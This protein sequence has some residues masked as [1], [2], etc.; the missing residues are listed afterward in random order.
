MTFEDRVN[1]D[2]SRGSR[3]YQEDNFAVVN[4]SERQ[5]GGVEHTLLVLADGMG[6]HAGGREAS[7]LAVAAFVDR[8]RRQSG[9]VP[10]RLRHSLH[11]ANDKLAEAIEADPALQDMGCTLVGV[12]I[13]QAGVQWVSVGDSPLWLVSGSNFRQLNTDHSMTPVLQD[14]VESGRMTAEEAA[15]DRRRNALRSAV[16]GDEIPMV[17]LSSQPIQLS[18]GDRIILASDGLQTLSEA[19]IGQVVSELAEHP[20]LNVVNRLLE[21]VESKALPNQDNTT[22]IAAYPDPETHPK[23]PTPNVSQNR[24]GAASGSQQNTGT[25]PVFRSKTFAI[26]IL[27]LLF[28]LITAAV[29]LLRQMSSD[30]TETKEQP[31]APVVE[32]PAPITEETDPQSDLGADGLEEQTQR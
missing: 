25:A 14:L 4:L 20:A 22:V 15:T 17:D 10:D 31:A 2:Q 32:N 30:P 27:V 16:M 24:G 3:E 6:G 7:E 11:A 18:S 29:V 8:Y 12:V 1:G 26:T 21:G 19:E 28:I 23:G 5:N 9:P 13:N